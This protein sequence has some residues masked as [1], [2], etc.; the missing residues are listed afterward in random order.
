LIL[1]KSGKKKGNRRRT[2]NAANILIQIDHKNILRIPK[3][4]AKIAMIFFKY[5]LN[6]FF[7][8]NLVDRG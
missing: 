8:Q 1:Q 3:R 5:R 2:R 4:A 6:R 7:R